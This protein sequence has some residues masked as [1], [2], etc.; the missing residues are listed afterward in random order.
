MQN[1]QLMTDT[2]HLFLGTV[3]ALAAALDA[4]HPYTHGHA[5][6]V[7][8]L[9]AATADEMQL[10]G[11]Y[12]ESLHLTALLHDFG[13]IGIARSILD[14]PG[15]LTAEEWAIVKQ[16]PTTGAEIVAHMEH[17]VMKRVAQALQ[18]HHEWWDGTGYPDGLAGERIPVE[19]R[20]VSVVDAFCVM[21]CGR[22][23]R[24]AQSEEQTLAEIERCAGTQFDPAVAEALT[25]SRRANPFPIVG[26]G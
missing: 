14:K 6:T 22:P 7:A 2:R 17:P 1:T 8:A 11:E 18:S 25:A 16:H 5:R 23:Y 19:S 24:P 13:K 21:V 12:R 15:P 4:R 10:R 20:I 9:C 3:E 26:R